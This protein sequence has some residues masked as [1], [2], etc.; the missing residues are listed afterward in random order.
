MLAWTRLPLILPVL[1]GGCTQGFD[2][3]TQRERINDGS[4]QSD[5]TIADAR[6]V[7]PQLRFPCRIAVYLRPNERDWRWTPEDKAAMQ[8]WGA[9]LVG[10]GIASDV[11][12]L[13]ELVLAAEGKTADTK[14]LRLAAARCGADALFVVYGAAQTESYKNAASV[15]DVTLVGGFVVPSKHRDALFAIEGVLLDV[16]NGY[17]YTGAQAE[18]EG[19]IIRPT[20]LVED[21]DAIAKAK[22]KAL[23]QFGDEFLRRMRA[24]A[25]SPPVPR[26]AS[27]VAPPPVKPTP[28]GLDPQAQPVLR[29]LG[30]ADPLTGGA[31]G[32]M[33][34]ITVPRPTP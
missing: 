25:A 11:F 33:T 13:P 19:K 29:A 34:G 20:F 14:A 21:K 26:P 10:E 6:T 24:L 32:V 18:G 12:P 23:R 4:L 9:A 7:Q 17:I 3:S 2:R 28:S 1:L 8:H 22:A 5:A 30:L 27:A 15:F 16:D 31:G